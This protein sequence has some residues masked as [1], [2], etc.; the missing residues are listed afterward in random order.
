MQLSGFP[1]GKNN[2]S[3]RESS[4]EIYLLSFCLYCEFTISFLESHTLTTAFRDRQKG[5]SGTNT[6]KLQ[7]YYIRKASN[8]KGTTKTT[9]TMKRL[10]KGNTTKLRRNVF[11]ILRDKWVS[12][13]FII[14]LICGEMGID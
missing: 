4:I 2:K 3:L 6:Q 12:V 13:E 5:L 9:Y 14:V 10:N 8:W 1:Q 7:D 11:N